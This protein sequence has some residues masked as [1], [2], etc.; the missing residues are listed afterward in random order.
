MIGLLFKNWLF[1]HLLRLTGWGAAALSVLAVL[2]GAR[3]AGRKAERMDQMKKRVEVQNDQLR[4]TVEA[5]RS[6]DDLIK[7]LR[8]GKL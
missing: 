3:Q 4:A 6:R 2:C 1:S 8:K 7:W 5:P